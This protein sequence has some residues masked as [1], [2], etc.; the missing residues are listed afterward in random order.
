MVVIISSSASVAASNSVRPRRTV[1]G[2]PMMLDDWR[3]AMISRSS[4]VYGWAAASSGDGSGPGRPE[5][6]R[7]NDRAPGPARNCAR[8]SVSAQIT[9]AAIMA[10]GRCSVPDGRNRS[11]YRASAG[12]VLAALKWFAN[13]NGRPSSPATCA[14]YPL[15]PSSH[16]EG[17]LPWPGTA[18]MAA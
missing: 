18:V 15:D 2:E 3:E 4:E 5:R 6:S 17:L 12:R 10:C 11:R 13:A 16:I 1:S 9:A 7:R 14:L 8:S